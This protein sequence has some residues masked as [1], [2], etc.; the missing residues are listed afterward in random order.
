[1]N[2]FRL[3]TLFVKSWAMNLRTEEKNISSD[4]IKAPGHLALSF[5]HPDFEG[6]Y[7]LL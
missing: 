3:F 4:A 2:E 6:N 7:E 5:L 1:M